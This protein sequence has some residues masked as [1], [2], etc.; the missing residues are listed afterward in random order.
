MPIQDIVNALGPF[1][2]LQAMVLLAIAAGMGIAWWRSTITVRKERESTGDGNRL[3]TTYDISLVR[4]DIQR[5]LS[6]RHSEFFKRIENLQSRVSRIEGRL[7]I[8][9]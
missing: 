6:D 1:P 2:L 4:Q 8:I 3:A 9:D 5:S 7:E